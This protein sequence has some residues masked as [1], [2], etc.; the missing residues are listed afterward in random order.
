VLDNPYEIMR[1]AGGGFGNPGE[2]KV[3]VVARRKP[4]GKLLVCAWAADDTTRVVPVKL[5][6]GKEVSLEATPRGSLYWGDDGDLERIDEGRIASLVSL[7][8]QAAGANGAWQSSLDIER[9][10]SSIRVSLSLRAESRVTLG[11]YTLQGRC[12]WT[13][14][15]R[16]R[17]GRGSLRVPTKELPHG[18]HVIRVRTGTRT[19]ASSFVTLR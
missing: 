16:M 19:T 6:G 3:R 14:S 18:T 17:P 13:D 11:V 9:C 4:D 8:H 5:P 15:R 12:L 7:R 1:N 2:G 10:R